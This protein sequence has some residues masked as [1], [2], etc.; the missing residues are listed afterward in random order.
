[1]CLNKFYIYLHIKPTIYTYI[2]IIYTLRLSLKFK[3]QLLSI[4]LC[5]VQVISIWFL[6]MQIKIVVFLL[7][8]FSFLQFENKFQHRNQLEKIGIVF[9]WSLNSISMH[10]PMQYVSVCGFSLEFQGHPT[11][12]WHIWGLAVAFKSS[13]LCSEYCLPARP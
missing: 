7:A 1:M 13:W 10:V 11:Y 4:Y 9:P 3:H 12:T 8:S 2:L 6:T 5:R